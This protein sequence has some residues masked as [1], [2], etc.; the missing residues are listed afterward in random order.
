VVDLLHQQ[1]LRA[2]GEEQLQQQ[3]PQN[4][5]LRNRRPPR[6]LIQ[7]LNSSLNDRE[8]LSLN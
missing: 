8:A 6:R 7:P 1:P 3:G 5:L 4:V 2:D